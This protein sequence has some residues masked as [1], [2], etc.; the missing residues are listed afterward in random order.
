MLLAARTDM[1]DAGRAVVSS[2][3]VPAYD[4]RRPHASK[5][6]LRRTFD[7]DRVSVKFILGSSNDEGSSEEPFVVLRAY[8]GDSDTRA[9]LVAWKR[10]DDLTATRIR[11]MVVVLERWSERREG[12]E[13]RWKEWVRLEFLS[14][15]GEF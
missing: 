7:G 6:L 2:T 4:P 1:G 14:W 5:T 8:G 9:A 11:N 15:E 3:L 12:R 10:A 13:G